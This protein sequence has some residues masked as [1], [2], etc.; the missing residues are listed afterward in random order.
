MIH[1]RPPSHLHARPLAL[2]RRQEIMNIDKWIC[3]LILMCMVVF[4]RLMFLSTLML[5]EWM[6]R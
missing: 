2:V 1:A 5:K 3:F 6:S 4:Y